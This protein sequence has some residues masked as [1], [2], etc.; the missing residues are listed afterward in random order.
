MGDTA[1]TRSF[2]NDRLRA[3]GRG[4]P[5][6]HRTFNIL[7]DRINRMAPVAGQPSLVPDRRSVPAFWI[8]EEDKPIDDGTDPAH[9][10]LE[11]R[12]IYDKKADRSGANEFQ[13]D[14]G[15][16]VRVRKRAYVAVKKFDMGILT[17]CG[18]DMPIFEPI[19]H[20]NLVYRQENSNVPANGEFWP[21]Y[22][23]D[24]DLVILGVTVRATAGTYELKLRHD[25][26]TGTVILHFDE[27]NADV[28]LEQTANP[29]I[30]FHVKEGDVLWLEQVD[31]SAPEDLQVYFR[32][33]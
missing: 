9:S 11:V 14:Q 20:H 19:R 25:S 4:E 3:A 5:I 31:S 24:R 32:T 21:A 18:Q 6:D 33:L 23:A 10:V 29:G 28:F 16:V 2:D 13:H 8:A 15:K 17:D 26:K 12:P 27:T 7:V 1:P 22:I 30:G